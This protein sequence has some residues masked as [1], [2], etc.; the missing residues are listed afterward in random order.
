MAKRNQ[1]DSLPEPDTAPEAAAEPAAPP[2][3]NRRPN[4]TYQRR[5]AYLEGL[6]DAALAHCSAHQMT[7]VGVPER[8][9]DGKPVMD[10]LTRTPK[11]AVRKVLLRD[12]VSAEHDDRIAAF[13]AQYPGDPS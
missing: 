11:L 10:P 2:K 6:K 12:L 7:E 3:S 5:I 9:E 8:D 1:K 4:L 13:K